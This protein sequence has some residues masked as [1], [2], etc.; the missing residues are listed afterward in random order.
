M[1]HL[2]FEIG[3]EELPSWYVR[4]A[5]EALA[6]LAS[7]RL[8]AAQLPFASFETLATPRRLALSV[9]GLADASRSRE[10]LK[11]GPAKEVAYTEDG[12]PSKA[13][14]GFAKANGVEPSDLK[15]G[16]AHV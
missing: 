14:L 10:E 5:Q 4:Q 1:P 2:L 6:R 7:E 12:G 9:Q 15:I 11:R 16:R 13:L 8:L 3:T